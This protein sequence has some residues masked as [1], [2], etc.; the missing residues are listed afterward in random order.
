[1][2]QCVKYPDWAKRAG[3]CYCFGVSF[4]KLSGESKL[5]VCV[6]INEEMHVHQKIFR[7]IKPGICPSISFYKSQI[8]LEMFSH[9]TDSC[10][11][12]S[13]HTFNHTFSMQSASWI[14]LHG[15]DSMY[16][17]VQWQ[18]NKENTCFWHREWGVCQ[19]DGGYKEHTVCVQS[20]CPLVVWGHWPSVQSMQHYLQVALQYFL[21]VFTVI[22]L[23]VPL[24]EDHCYPRPSHIILKWKSDIWTLFHIYHI[25]HHIFHLSL[26]TV[27]VGCFTIIRTH[28]EDVECNHCPRAVTDFISTHC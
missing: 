22:R 12:L 23:T 4:I 16:I 5:N 10:T 21:H 8:N 28:N 2:T 11:A 1:M 17:T 24:G 15:N 26:V 27:N 9:V 3:Y 6:H 13:I 25:I 19:W 20:L 14:L 7:L 18:K